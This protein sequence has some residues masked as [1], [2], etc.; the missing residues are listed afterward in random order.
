[1]VGDV[2]I[3][4]DNNEAYLCSLGIR[5]N[6][7]SGGSCSCHHYRVIY[8]PNLVAQVHLVSP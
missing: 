8:F 4:E 2:V 5:D 3:Y 7:G 6:N 1:M